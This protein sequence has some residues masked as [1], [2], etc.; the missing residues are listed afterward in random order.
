MTQIRAG[1]LRYKDKPSGSPY[2]STV[3][4]TISCSKCGSHMP[5]SSM[6]TFRVAGTLH[7][8]CEQPCTQPKR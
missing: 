5:R 2:E 4:R 3:G 7:Y 6:V 1:G 8:R